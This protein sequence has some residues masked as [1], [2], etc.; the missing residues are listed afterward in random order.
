[1]SPWDVWAPMIGGGLT[2]LIGTLIFW[3]FTDRD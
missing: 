2:A 1:M 3:R